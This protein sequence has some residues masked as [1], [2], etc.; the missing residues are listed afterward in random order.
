MLRDILVWRLRVGRHT[1]LEVDLIQN[2]E[3][4]KDEIR[5]FCQGF[6]PDVL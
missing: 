5:T 6:V 2:R 4:L 1:G 3:N